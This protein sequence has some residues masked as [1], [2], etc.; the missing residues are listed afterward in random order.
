M[1]GVVFVSTIGG[2][3]GSFFAQQQQHV[4]PAPPRCPSRP[5]RRQSR[6]DDDDL[7][8]CPQPPS[9]RMAWTGSCSKRSGSGPRLLLSSGCESLG[10]WSSRRRRCCHRCQHH[11][12]WQQGS[13]H[14]LHQQRGHDRASQLRRTRNSKYGGAI[15]IH[16]SGAND[17]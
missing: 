4:P 12:C 5:T 13:R 15:S 3:V 16:L 17:L 1:Y 10:R 8:F 9:L 11:G 7:A 14:H 2:K 6:R